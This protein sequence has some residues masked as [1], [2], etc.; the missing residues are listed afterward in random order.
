MNGFETQIKILASNPLEYSPVIIFGNTQKDKETLIQKIS[1]LKKSKVFDA[2]EICKSIVASI[3]DGNNTWKEQFDPYDVIIIDDENYLAGK[4]TTQEML[5][6]YFLTCNKAIVV[7]T[8]SEMTGNAFS[9][10]FSSFFA[11]G[12]IIHIY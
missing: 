5:L 2:E 1:T 9:S 6:S 3:I 10:E 12:T 8:K 4:T 11:G 7:I